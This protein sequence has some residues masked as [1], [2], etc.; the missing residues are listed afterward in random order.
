MEGEP[1]IA[2]EDPHSLAPIQ[3]QV[4]NIE[5]DVASLHKGEGTRLVIAA[6]C[7][8]VVAFGA[9]LWMNNIDGSQAYAAAAERLEVIN[10]QQGSALLRCVL[11]DFPRAQLKSSQALH[12][13]LENASERAQKYYGKQLKQCARLSDQLVRRIDAVEVPA[14]QYR[15]IQRLK[16]S[17]QALDN[18]LIAYRTYL[19]DPNVP[20]DYVQ[21]TALIEHIAIAWTTYEAQRT[22]LNEALREHP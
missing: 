20:Y 10:S 11:P 12:T 2:R 16:S 1:S 6:L 13:A 9:V 5:D 7:S 18:S 19:Q 17:A 8:G 22:Q 21:A 14:D 3:I 15:G 4:T